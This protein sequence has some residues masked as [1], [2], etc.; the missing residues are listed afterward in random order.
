VSVPV[1]PAALAQPRP[2][3]PHPAATGSRRPAGDLLLVAQGRTDPASATARARC[4]ADPGQPGRGVA[5][6]ALAVAPEE[7]PFKST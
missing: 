1:Q 3:V 6:T 5:R 2:A 7:R 4:A